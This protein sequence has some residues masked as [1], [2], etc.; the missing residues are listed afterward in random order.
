MPEPEP[1]P[2]EARVTFAEFVTPI[3]GSVG[4][5]GRVM[6]FCTSMAASIAIF[7]WSTVCTCGGTIGSF[8]IFGRC[9]LMGST[10]SCEPPPPPPPFASPALG[11]LGSHTPTSMLVACNC[12]WFTVSM[13]FLTPKTTKN[14]KKARFTV[15]EIPIAQGLGFTVIRSGTGIGVDV[16]SSGG[17]WGGKKTSRMLS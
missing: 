15:V 5:S 4:L 17:K 12:C 9:P 8:S 13:I 14:A 7:G 3:V 6:F 10:I 1:C 11:A 16:S 2:F